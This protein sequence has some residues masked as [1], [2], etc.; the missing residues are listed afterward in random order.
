MYRKSDGQLYIEDFVLPF[1]GKLQADN[2]WVKLAKLIPWEAIEEKYAE[3]FP[4]RRGQE[5]KPARMALGALI[6]KEKGGYSDRETV[7]Q[8]V[9]NPYLQYFIG[10]K[11]YQAEAPFDPSLMVHFRKRFD[12]KT[13][14]EINEMICQ[15]IEESAKE[16]EDQDDDHQ[17]PSDAECSHEAQAESPVE[18]QPENQGKLILDAT[19][20]P[21]DI[22]YPSDLSLLNEARQKLDLIIDALC[23]ALGG[24]VKRPRTYR[25]KAQIAFLA[26]TRR[27]KGKKDIMRKAVGAQLRYVKRNLDAVDRLLEKAKEKG[28]QR[29][30]SNRQEG[31]LAVIREVYRQQKYMHAN[32][33]RRVE[34]RIVSISQPHVR[35]IVRGKAGAEVEFGAK[36]A[37]SVVNGLTRVERLDWEAF[38]EGSTLIE[39][40]E[41]YYQRYGYFPESVLADKLYRTRENLQ[42][43]KSKGIRLS[44]PRLGR[45][46]HSEEKQKEQVRL[47]RQDSRER[48]A[49]EGKIGEA[50]RRY[51]MARIMAR[52]KET[53]ASV[54]CLQVVVMNLEHHLRALFCLLLSWRFWYSDYRRISLAF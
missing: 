8:I 35:P 20:A 33:V 38:N 54:I 4:G 51:G 30:L 24:S 46:S 28:C 16:D 40:V 27:R 2:R 36:V 1:S 12:E 3:H 6:I 7:N 50:K 45:P 14:M 21:A 32:R 15:A 9:E 42:Y 23:K 44:G 48:N 29:A 5:A 18:N 41:A 13:M 11:E 31:D 10:L 22:R 17:P 34:K 52:L 19:C 47:E 53:A 37:I 39:A 26:A 49:V 43:C 25:I